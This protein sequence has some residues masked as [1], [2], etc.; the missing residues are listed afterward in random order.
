MYFH[1]P[2]Y[3]SIVSPQK[4]GQNNKVTITI[5]TIK[6]EEVLKNL[7]IQS[8]CTYLFFSPTYCIQLNI[9]N[10]PLLYSNQIIYSNI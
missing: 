7:L 2:I 9:I 5:N 8:C 3:S 6:R 10:Y 4:N 1:V